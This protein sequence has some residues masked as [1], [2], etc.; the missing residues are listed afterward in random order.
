M[1]LAFKDGCSA[2][3]LVAALLVTWP[4][5]GRVHAQVSPE[6]APPVPPASDKFD[7]IQLTSDEWLKGEIIALYDEKL[8]FDSDK[9]DVLTLDWEDVKQV[10]SAGTVQVAIVDGEPATGKLVIDGNKVQLIGDETRRLE[11]SQILT[12]T[13]GDPREINFWSGKVN[14]GSNFRQGNSDQVEVNINTRIL[15]RT[16][17]NRVA[18]EYFA[19]YNLTEDVVVTNNH[20]ASVGWDWFVSDWLFVRPIHGEYYR[21]P[22]QN[23]AQRWTISAGFG[24]QI[25]NTSKIDWETSVGPG[26]QHTQFDGVLEG[27]SDSESTPAVSAGTVYKNEISDS[28]DYLFDFNF[29]LTQEAAGLYSHHLITGFDFDLAG[30]LDLNISFAWDRIQKPRPDSAGALPKKDDYRT[31]FGVG[32]EF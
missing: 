13:V 18:F 1:S 2:R 19:N 31:V 17:R 4:I 10:R 12:I 32:V 6:V 15:R 23:I 16:I 8:E 20:H 26:Y 24:I 21:D 27:E 14:V 7:W 25:V 29:L 30:V 3:F 5:A 11:R 22:F 9:L 28:I